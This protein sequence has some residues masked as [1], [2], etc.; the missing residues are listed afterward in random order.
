MGND[1]Q[2]KINDMMVELIL[3]ALIL[4]ALFVAWVYPRY[5]QTEIKRL[6]DTEVEVT[7]L[8]TWYGEWLG[9]QPEKVIYKHNYYEYV[10]GGNGWVW[11]IKST[12]EKIGRAPE[13]DAALLQGQW[14][15]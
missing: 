7:Y 1:Y 12:G 2:L 9:R 8:P 11:H 6:S 14:K 4:V 15:K 10:F 3:I 13:F 5:R